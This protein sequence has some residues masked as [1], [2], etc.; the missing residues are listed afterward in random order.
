MVPKESGLNLSETASGLCAS[1][2]RRFLCSPAIAR[3]G[4]ILTVE[5]RLQSQAP[6]TMLQLLSC[7]CS[8]RC[9][10]WNVSARATA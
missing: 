1:I 7:T 9:N 4:E 5:W 3:D 10:S 6:D 8:R 2:V